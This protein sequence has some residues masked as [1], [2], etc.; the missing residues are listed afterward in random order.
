MTSSA[1]AAAASVQVVNV[2]FYVEDEHTCSKLDHDLPEPVI[3]I[4]GSLP[5]GERACVHVH[6]VG[7]YDCGTLHEVMAPD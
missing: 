7:R 1:R 2:D 5:S 4:F 6:G 3:R